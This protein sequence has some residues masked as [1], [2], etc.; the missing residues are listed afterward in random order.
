MAPPR[1]AGSL[2]LTFI[3]LMAIGISPQ[4]S[5]YDRVEEYHSRGHEWPPPPSEYVPAEPGWRS[6]FERRL[7]QLAR[8]AD[9]EGKYNGYMGAIHSA[10]L[11][12]NFTEYGWGLTRAPPDLVRALGDNLRRG[13]ETKDSPEEELG[14]EVSEAYPLM[15]PLMIPNDSL[16]LRA[17]GELKHIHEA[18]SG[19]ELVA[20][21]AYG[22][23]VYR[24]QS[25]L[26]MHVD[27]SST[28]VI[29]SI[30]HVGHDPNGEPWP[31]IIEDLRG[32]TNEVYLEAGDMLLYESSKCYHG[33]PRRY[34]G[35]WYSS[36]FTHY[37]PVGWDGNKFEMD[38][39]YRVPPEWAEL[40]EE[41]AVEGLEELVVS[42][43][44]LSEPDCEHGWCRMKD[45][46]IWERPEGLEFGQV[47][48]GDGK[49]RSLGLDGFVEIEE[50]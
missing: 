4:L 24:N 38:A 29:S 22:L 8:I 31:L 1:M 17:M 46:I 26:L 16:N 23:R 28:H 3:V 9:E 43:T 34:N 21:N 39:H 7:D 30:L 15:R 27:E 45:T 33:R 13:L 42:E 47:L 20:N 12:P 25:R 6:I 49:V 44:S 19:V 2:R 37:Y 41:E 35:A 10:L 32:N 48:S 5:E 18:W 11:A 14:H 36:L 40:P 50:L